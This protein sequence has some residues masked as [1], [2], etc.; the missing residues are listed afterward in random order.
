MDADRRMQAEE[1]LMGHPDM[2]DRDAVDTFVSNGI[3]ADE[4]EAWSLLARLRD[5]S[6]DESPG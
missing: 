3:C 2:S 5:L 1:I 4:Q 6:P